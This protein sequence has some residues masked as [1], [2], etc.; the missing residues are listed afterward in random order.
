MQDTNSQSG[1][2]C[3][4]SACILLAGRDTLTPL[5]GVTG[6]NRSEKLKIEVHLPGDLASLKIPGGAQ[7]PGEA[8]LGFFFTIYWC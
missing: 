8:R 1:E 2:Y 5:R 6:M 7:G 3:S 4:E